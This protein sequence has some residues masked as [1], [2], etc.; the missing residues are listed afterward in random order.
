MYVPC[1]GRVRLLLDSV[2]GALVDA[3]SAVDALASVDDG[4]VIDG[5][6]VLGADVRAGSA[7]N[8]VISFHCR[9]LMYLGWKILL[10][11]FNGFS[12]WVFSGILRIYT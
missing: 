10:V 2:G 3:G 12:C 5:D 8:T 11:L 1:A 9:H 7:A 6:C 4:D